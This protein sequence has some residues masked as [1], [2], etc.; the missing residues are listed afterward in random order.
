MTWSDL[1]NN[2]LM[3]DP[4][5][6]AALRS[7][8]FN[9]LSTF[10]WFLLTSFVIV[11]G[12]Y[13]IFLRFLER[14]HLSRTRRF[15]SIGLMVLFRILALT[16]IL[17]LLAR[18]SLVL[19]FGGARPRPL[20]ILLDH[21][22]SMTQA[23]RRLSDEDKLR[24]ALAL[25]RLPINTPMTRPLPAL[26]SDVPAEPDRFTLLKGILE[27]KHLNLL[28]GL[29][30]KAPLRIY[31]FGGQLRTLHDDTASAGSPL[32][33]LRS[34]SAAQDFDS[35]TALWDVVHG[36]LE[37][38]DSDYPAGIVIMTDGRD[39][40]SKLAMHEVAT[41]CGELQIPL[42]IY[43]V[44]SSEGAS[45]Q[46]K[47]L[48][49]PETIFYDDKVSVA[50]R[51]RAQGFK[52]GTKVRVNLTL[53]G[54]RVA[55]RE[56]EAPQNE[57]FR[58]EDIAFEWKK[59][60]TQKSDKLELA[61][62]VEIVG[63]EQEFADRVTRPVRVVDAK[64]KV[65]YIETAPRW[66]FRY[67]Q[68]A[69]LMRD[70]RVEARFLVLQAD[71]QVLKPPAIKDPDDWP[72]LAE[73]PSREKLFTYDVVIL[74][75]VSASWLGQ[76]RI[77]WLRDFVYEGG[78]GL[79]HI[80][81]QQHGPATYVNTPLA[82][83]L[84]VEFDTVSFPAPGSGASFSP[85]A[86]QTLSEQKTPYV[87]ILTEEGEASPML[88]LADTPE[89]SLEVWKTM[90]ALAL[91]REQMT[92]TDGRPSD[93]GQV[94]LAQA[95]KLANEGWGFYW[96]YPVKGLR[97]GATALFVHPTARIGKP[98]SKR[99][100][101]PMPIMA[102]QTYGNGPVLFLASDET[103]RWRANGCDRHVARLWGQI[104]Y[105]MGMRHVLG[106]GRR[107]HM[108]L[109]GGSEPV[110]DR[111]GY[112]HVTVLDKQY[113][114]FV[115]LGRQGQIKPL[116]ARLI[117]PA[118]PTLPSFSGRRSGGEGD[119]R[120]TSE[121]NLT[122][123][124]VPGRPGRYRVLLTHS[125]TGRHKIQLTYP[126]DFAYEYVVSLAPGHEMEPSG[127]AEEELREAA[128]LSGHPQSEYPG[129][130]YREEDLHKLVD[131]VKPQ[132][133]PFT[134][135]QPMELLMHRPWIFL[136]IVALLCGDWLVRKFI[137]LS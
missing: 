89:E 100:E 68:Q 124:P 53:G 52:K 38:K 27:N 65:L 17:L 35:K 131:D 59:T 67:L 105:E 20:A 78:G 128:R 90:P 55:S 85:K 134:L 81:G 13:V 21:S 117:G 103:W 70:R 62:A 46:L 112:L 9:A 73:F 47:H 136:L 36:F 92:S 116:Q 18:L 121:Q 37:R 66:E 8:H 54:K 15:V 126:E 61:A 125:Q 32:S 69:Y 23:D 86:W 95:R 34:L 60:G 5:E 29:R 82:E 41:R 101:Q 30:T 50:I 114:P 48:A 7:V 57:D 77:T 24:V 80:A 94:P 72:Y 87:P 130:F 51:G 79:I 19:E 63:R 42:Y 10:W 107:V 58:V 113:R 12:G 106:G 76:E 64:V 28:D 123:E 127:M 26:P 2:M 44:G 91:V 45:L 16:L 99:G 104:I 40:A 98:G 43:G 129:K 14:N 25:E 135:L 74:G 31:A 1:V 97:A 71:P 122:L 108:S 119:G 84:P 120:P 132:K 33:G 96:H 111:Q 3:V 93:S 49:A 6:G 109:Q 11:V 4:P 115:E 88:M 39:N 75:D 133:A 83:M 102:V 56:V 118:P 22:Q 137:N 110:R